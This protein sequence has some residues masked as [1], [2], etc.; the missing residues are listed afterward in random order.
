MPSAAVPL[1]QEVTQGRSC[2]P[3]HATAP[4]VSLLQAQTCNSPRQR[5]RL[6]QLLHRIKANL[7]LRRGRP[8]PK[9]E[10][11]L[12]QKGKG[13]MSCFLCV[14]SL[15][16]PTVLGLYFVPMTQRIRITRVTITSASSLPIQASPTFLCTEG[17]GMD[18]S[19][20]ASSGNFGQ[21][22]LPIQGH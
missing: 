2:S 4:A 14:L 9:A 17:S 12:P 7:Y 1:Q 16:C 22:Q 13:K 6:T 18:T 3:E 20:R 10:V 5:T 21:H 19:E 8:R 15:Q 11:V